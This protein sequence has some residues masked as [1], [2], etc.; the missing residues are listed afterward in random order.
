MERNGKKCAAVTGASGHIGRGIAL[1]LAGRGFEIA[2]SYAKNAEGAFETKRLVEAKGGSCKL[3]EARLD[4]TDG[5]SRLVN[6]IR[7]DFGRIDAIVCNAGKDTRG[8]VLTATSAQ[9][10]YLYQNN[11]RNYYLCVGAA[12]RHM[13]RDEIKGSIVLITSV[14]AKRAHPDDFLYGSIK[15]AMERACESMALDLSPYGIRVNCVAP[16]AIW[17][18]DKFGNI[19]LTPFVRESIPMRRCGTSAEIGDVV[20]YL[21]C[22]ESSYVTGTTLLVDGGLSLPGMNEE[23]APTKW[24]SEGWAEKNRTAAMKI[25]EDETREFSE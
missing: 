17:H 6:A 18:P 24:M 5:P 25:L 19:P 11:L 20:A 7:R 2:A 10:D 9:L 16:G 13:V 8:S 21:A 12:A 22:D 1:S 3:Y 23:G 4:E 14:R 15:A